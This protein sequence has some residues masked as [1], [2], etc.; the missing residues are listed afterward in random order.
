MPD[1]LP[2]PLPDDPLP[3]VE[4][5]LADAGRAVPNPTAMTLATVTGAGRPDQRRGGQPL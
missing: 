5:W 2:D 3:I 4:S 1:A